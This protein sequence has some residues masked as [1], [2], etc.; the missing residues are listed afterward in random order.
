MQQPGAKRETGGTDFKWGAGDHWLPL[1]TALVKT[2]VTNHLC[3]M[4]PSRIHK[5]E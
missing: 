2:V 1:A 5:A 3:K 4:F